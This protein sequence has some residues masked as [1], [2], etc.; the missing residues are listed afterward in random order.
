MSSQ[1]LNIN[2]I[3]DKNSNFVCPTCGF[4]HKNE[5]FLKEK[6]MN[7]EYCKP[8]KKTQKIEQDAKIILKKKIYPSEKN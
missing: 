8:E 4:F 2:V 5:W 1:S 3:Q 7:S 6:H